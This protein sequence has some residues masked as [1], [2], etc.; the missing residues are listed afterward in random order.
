MCIC[1][2]RKMY[3]AIM[4]ICKTLVLPSKLRE[5]MTSP[6]LSAMSLEDSVA[7]S[8]F[9]APLD[10]WL[11][12]Q[13]WSASSCPSPGHRSLSTPWPMEQ[14]HLMDHWW[15]RL[16][17]SARPGLPHVR[18]ALLALFSSWPTDM[19][20]GGTCHVRSKWTQRRWSKVEWV[21]KGRENSSEFGRPAGSVLLKCSPKPC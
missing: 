20:A 3:E 7:L 19:V 4:Q 5:F 11:L 1:F 18:R 17:I 13:A 2:M 12:E 6:I 10:S 14:S 8:L 16:P 9:A 21:A 15:S